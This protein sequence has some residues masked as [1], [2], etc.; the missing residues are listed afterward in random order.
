MFFSIHDFDSKKPVM[1][2]PIV[3]MHSQHYVRVG[4]DDLITQYYMQDKSLKKVNVSKR[5]NHERTVDKWELER[6]FEKNSAS[7]FDLKKEKGVVSVEP[8]MKKNHV[9]GFTQRKTIKNLPMPK[10]GGLH[11]SN[12]H[13]E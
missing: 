7:M 5:G 11:G 9:I 12:S 10:K 8:V 1:Y 6:L 2:P 4:H 3:D 13:P